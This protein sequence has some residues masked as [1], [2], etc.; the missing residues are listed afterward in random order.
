[1]M[2]AGP[3]RDPSA[4]RR[5]VGPWLGSV[6]SAAVS[7]PLPR[8]ECLVLAFMKNKARFLWKTGVLLGV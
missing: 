3:R 8:G 5:P 1:M 4:V 6:R 7:A 2:A